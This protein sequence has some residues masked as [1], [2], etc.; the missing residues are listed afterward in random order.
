VKKII[1]FFVLISVFFVPQSAE[2]AYAAETTEE[3]LDEAVTEA[4]DNIDLSGYESLIDLL[5]EYNGYGF[6]VSA[7]R[8]IDDI[9]HGKA[10]PT[11]EYFFSSAIELLAG[12]MT[13]LAPQL[14]IIVIIAVLYGVLKNL[15]SGFLNAGTQKVVFLACYALVITVI[16]YMFV[17][18]VKSAVNTFE[19]I[20]KFVD[21]GF[22]VLITLVTALGGSATVAV[23]QPYVLIFSE[24]L[25]TMVTAVIMPLFYITFIFGIVGNLSENLKLDK[26]SSVTKSASEWIMGIV[27]GTFITLLTAQG[28]TG[29]S[30]D[31]LAM[32]GA[33]YAL[34][35]Y[36]PVI[37]NYLKDGF[38]IVMASCVVIKNAVG[39]CALIIL[40]TGI[41]VPLIKITVMSL[42]LRLAAALAEPLSDG[43]MS[44]V[45]HTA[46]ESLKI[47]CV[48]IICTGV[49]MLIAIMLIIYTCNPGLL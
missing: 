30:F 36:V 29:A 7:R 23:Y 32:R 20:K 15:N 11:F 27:F 45:I 39:L 9:I 40:V 8:I 24:V 41:L 13:G 22:P 34:S 5:N 48:A 18:T 6:S 4:L 12:E 25:M 44:A 33:K 14:I 37:G 35:S 21:L 10:E 47:L 16:S 3:N 42:G 31:G 26:F 17:N 46:G 49:A 43:K 19:F 2:R 28:I 1:F 38:D